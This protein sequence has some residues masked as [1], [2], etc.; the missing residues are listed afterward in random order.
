MFISLHIPPGEKWLGFLFIF[1]YVS[2]GR[3]GVG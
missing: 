3:G 2:V 1:G